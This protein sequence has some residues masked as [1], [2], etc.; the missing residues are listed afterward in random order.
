MPAWSTRICARARHICGIGHPSTLRK[1]PYEPARV[2]A[3]PGLL[4]RRMARIPDPGTPASPD[5]HRCGT[6]FA[7]IP[8]IHGIQWNV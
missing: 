3:A 1:T 5:F 8:H 4:A 2:G 7:V 6:P